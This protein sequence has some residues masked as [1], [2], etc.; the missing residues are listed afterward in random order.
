MKFAHKGK[1]KDLVAMRAWAEEEVVSAR[2][3]VRTQW[4]L[5]VKT[6]VDQIQTAQ[7]IEEAFPEPKRGKAIC[8]ADAAPDLL[9]KTLAQDL[10]NEAKKQ[11][12]RGMVAV[13]NHRVAVGNKLNI[14]N[15]EF[16]QFAGTAYSVVNAVTEY[17]DWPE[18]ARSD[19]AQASLFGY[20]ATWKDRAWKAAMKI[21]TSDN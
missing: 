21:A 8:M 5:L 14:F 17:A 2:L 11:L 15:Q 18:K 16:P 1:V 13:E 7:I 4:E 9:Q 19:T 3:D 20:R 10:F 6:K 12:D